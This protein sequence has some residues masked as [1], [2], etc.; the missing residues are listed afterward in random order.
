MEDYQRE[1]FPYAYNIL[2]SV[3][4]A[5]DAVQEAILKFIPLQKDELRNERAYLVRM[6]I[7][8]A[9]NM[10]DRMKRL[11][12]KTTWLPEPMS[13]ESADENLNREELLSY[14]MLVLLEHLNARERAIFILKEAFSFSHHEIAQLL[15]MA[16]GNSRQ[17]LSRAKQKLQAHKKYLDKPKK[18]S[19]T[20][21]DQYLDVIGK[22]DLEALKLL[23]SNDISL[24]ADGGGKI[25][26]AQEV[27]VGLSATA[28]LI[29]F[30]YQ[31]YQ[32]FLKVSYHE[33]NHQPSLFYSKNGEI[34]ICQVFDLNAT[35]SQVN[36]I[37]SVVDPEKLNHFS[38]VKKGD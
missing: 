30:V 22:G 25:Q 19:T 21:F 11:A 13:T 8:Q 36:A 10:K 12:G 38:F 5:Q 9:I 26:V 1:L 34:V 18:M 20:F 15:S 32:Q 7:N 6:V 27:T 16:P 23:L 33:M 35:S 14:T 29:L 3:A 37:Y 31:K 17:I 28:D 2:G 24:T 4:D